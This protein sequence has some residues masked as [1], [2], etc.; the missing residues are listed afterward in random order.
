MLKV[1][2]TNFSM[3]LKDEKYQRALVIVIV[4]SKQ[5]V[6]KQD[7]HLAEGGTVVNHDVQQIS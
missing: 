3:L 6:R 7:P 4:P 1:K 5:R 2:T